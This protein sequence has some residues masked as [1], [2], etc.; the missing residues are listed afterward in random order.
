LTASLVEKSERATSDR[1]RASRDMIT[2]DQ[3]YLR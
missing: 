1:K 3:I 2:I